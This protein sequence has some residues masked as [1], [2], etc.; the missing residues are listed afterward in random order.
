M[1]GAVIHDT[2]T[3]YG[4]DKI[5]NSDRFNSLQ[6]LLRVTAYVQLFIESCK[7]GRTEGNVLS[8]KV[9]QKAANTWIRD[10]QRKCFPDAIRAS[11]WD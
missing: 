6:K 11:K 5:I 2:C 7:T 9:L 8:L 3:G 10:T 4:V 1:F